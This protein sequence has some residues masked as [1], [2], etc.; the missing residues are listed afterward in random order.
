MSECGPWA[1]SYYIYRNEVFEQTGSSMIRVYFLPL[2]LQR[3][4]V[5]LSDKA[6]AASWQNQLSGMYA[7]RRLRSAWTSADLSVRPGWSE[8]SLGA[9][10]FGLFCHEAAHLLF[11]FKDDYSNFSGVGISKIFMVHTHKQIQLS[12]RFGHEKQQQQFYDHSHPSADSRR[13]V[14]RMGTEYW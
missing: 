11:K 5:A 8:S 13:A 10:S 14:V 7:Q 4:S 1:S 6:W 2:C 9:Q 3:L 12:L